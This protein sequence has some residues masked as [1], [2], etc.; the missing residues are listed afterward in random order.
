[1]S[2]IKKLPTKLTAAAPSPFT[3][4]AQVKY[5]HFLIKIFA[6]DQHP[7]QFY[8]EPLV[9]LD[10]SSIVLMKQGF[11]KSD[12]LRLTIEMWNEELRCKV[13]ERLRQLDI[14]RDVKIEKDD[15]CIMPFEE[16]QLV[17]TSGSLPQSISLT[18][19]PKC[20]LRSNENLDLFLFCNDSSTANVL[21]HD[22]RQSPEFFITELSLK[23]Q[24][25]GLSIEAGTAPAG[26]TLP[27]RPT[28]SFKICVTSCQF[29][30]KLPLSNLLLV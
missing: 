7:R 27:E 26:S 29:T 20:Y 4:I 23:L 25:R 12:V 2:N 22:F 16:V 1:M 6:L 9:L 11:F 3:P 18:D 5:K 13:L 10:P 24:C 28:F 21:A 15:I 8:F 30:S 19:K 17:C 14:L